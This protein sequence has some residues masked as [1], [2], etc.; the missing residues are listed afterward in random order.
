MPEQPP[1]RVDAIDASSPT[2]ADA[3]RHV[4]PTAIVDPG[5]KLGRG[6]R[7]GP[8]A[9]IGAHVELGDGAIVHPHVVIDGHT[10]LG[11]GVEVFPGAAIGLRP[12]D[13]KY[14]GSPTRLVVGER[15]VLREHVTLQPGTRGGRGTGLT[16]VGARCLI[17]AYSHVAHDCTIGDD[18]VIANGTQ[19]AG[20]VTVE[21]HVILGGV[22]TVHQFVRIGARA[23]TG[24]SA[25]VQQDIPPFMLADGHPARLYGLNVVG[26]RRARLSKDALLALKRAYK[27]LFLRGS[28]RDALAELEATSAKDH[29]EVAELCRFLRGSERGVTR[30]ALRRRAGDPAEGEREG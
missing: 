7:I 8:Y 4:H 26:L 13:K 9:I 6:V 1:T 25:R 23:I 10:A 22:T 3:E 18:V 20:H 16:T 21:H 30:A 24:A 28:Y 12:Q 15:T 5:A 17:M 29:A 2:A 27:Q 11:A 14:D 19:I